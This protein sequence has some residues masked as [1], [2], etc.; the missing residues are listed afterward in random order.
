MITSVEWID[1]AQKLPKKEG[2]YLV[3]RVGNNLPTTRPFDGITFLTNDTVLYWSEL[4][5]YPAGFAERVAEQIQFDR[6]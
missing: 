1:V 4:P 3:L 5:Q 2:L 6:Y